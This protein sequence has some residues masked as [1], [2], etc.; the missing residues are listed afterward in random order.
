M[1]L[2]LKLLWVLWASVDPW[3]WLTIHKRRSNSLGSPPDH[4]NI[5]AIQNKAKNF[6]FQYSQVINQFQFQSK[7]MRSS[8]FFSLAVLAASLGVASALG[9]NCRGS[10]RCP[11]VRDTARDGKSIIENIQD[12]ILAS[13]KPD[14]TVYNSGDHVVC[15]LKYK[16]CLF[17]QGAALTLGQIKPLITSLIVHNCGSCGSVPI[18]FVDQAGNNDPRPGILTFNYVSAKRCEGQCI[19][20]RDRVGDRIPVGG[21]G[22]T[23]PITILATFATPPL[24]T[25]ATIAT[26]TTIPTPQAISS[27]VSCL[28]AG[29]DE[30]AC[31]GEAIP[32]L[33]TSATATT[34]PQY[35]H[36]FAHCVTASNRAGCDHEVVTSLPL[37]LDRFP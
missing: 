30:A 31:Y 7:K 5:Q 34:I 22:P 17:P 16:I 23:P 28:R 14:S 36:P 9:I 19:P 8:I 13:D 32:P 33:S 24:T 26:P 10:P 3:L 2:D 1:V 20:V 6:T 25:L 11:R 35:D 21:P 18:H 4:I 37:N 12:A 27:V 29:K 15:D